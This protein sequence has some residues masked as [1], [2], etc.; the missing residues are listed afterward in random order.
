MKS[1]KLKTDRHGQLHNLKTSAGHRN[2]TIY[3]L[4]LGTDNQKI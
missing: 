1:N 2:Y 4:L 3:R